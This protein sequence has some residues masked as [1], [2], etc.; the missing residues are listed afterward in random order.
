MLN[1]AGSSIL[2]NGALVL[3]GTDEQIINGVISINNLTLNNASGATIAGG[4]TSITGT[5][6]PTA[7]TL[8]TGGRLTLKSTA[9]GTARV[10]QG[11]GTFITGNVN[12]ERY[13]AGGAATGTPPT[14]G[15]RGFRFIAH[16]FTTNPFLN[17]L[18]AGGLSVTGTG[19]SANGFTNNPNLGATNSPSA[20]NYDPTVTGAGTITPGNGTDPGWTAY[21][22]ANTGLWNKMQGIRALFRGTNTQ[23]LDG[24]NVYTVNPL[25]LTLTG[26]VNTG[27]QNFALPATADVVDPKWSLVGNPYPS[28]IEV[29]TLLFNKYNAGAGNIGA[30]A[31]VF[32][33]TKSGTLR[34]GY[35]MIDV[36]T[37]GS[38]ILPTCGVV[39]VQNTVNTTHNIPFAETDKSTGTPTLNFRTTSANNALVL[40]MKDVSGLELDNTYIRLNNNAA[41]TFENRDG[42][43]MLNDYAVYTLTPENTLLAIDSRPEPTV[44]SII[45]MG[46]Q[47]ATAQS[48]VLK[49]TEL[50]LPTRIEAYL[51]DKFLNVTTPLSL[52]TEYSFSVDPS[53]AA[54]LGNNRFEIVMRNNNALPATFLSVTAAQKNAGIEVSWTTANETN[55]SNYEVEESTDGNNFS[56]AT[57]VAANNATTNVYNWL[58][59]SIINGDNYYRIKAVEKNGTTKYSNVV[60]VKIGGKGAGFTVYPNPVKGG[61]V[62]LQMSNVEKGIYT[63]KI[64]NNIGQELAAKAINHNGGSATQTIDLG[65]GIASGS[66]NMQITNGTT[67]ITKTVIVE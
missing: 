37:A 33:P 19:G 11:T 63:V 51:K 24:N 4:T 18:V 30:A 44:E 50:A 34:G 59:A 6:T 7:G 13:F 57:S 31:Y 40:T 53:N 67:V 8:T 43:K 35:D 29:R 48:F 9:T 27:A 66:Y 52:G 36:S 56:K 12:V 39:L 17:T 46:V 55:M 58:D 20:F 45:P 1:N 47:S 10:A 49:A 2:G 65:K 42:G 60:K 26:A 21:T 3:N 23:G 62:S 5:F 64:Y 32:N 28:Q 25:T 22:N 38:Y 14:P 41:N 16:P 61:V 15:V 54:T